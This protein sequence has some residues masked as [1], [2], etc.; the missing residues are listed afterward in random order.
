MGQDF[1][2]RLRGHEPVCV[3]GKVLT[4]CLRSMAVNLRSVRTSVGFLGLMAQLPALLSSCRH[5]TDVLAQGGGLLCE[6]RGRPGRRGG[7]Q[8]GDG[9]TGPRP[10][11]TEEPLQLG[12]PG[13]QDGD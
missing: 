3:E 11:T 7:L 9:C 13:G 10:E 12:Q 1:K 6:H 4:V 8:G 5:H 2:D